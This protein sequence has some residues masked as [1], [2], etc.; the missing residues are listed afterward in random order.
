MTH[1]INDETLATLFRDARSYHKWRDK[2]VS[3][4]LLMALY[5]LLRWG[6]TAYNASPAHILFLTSK[7]AKEKLK[8]SLNP[9]NV[10]QCATAPAVAVL[11]YDL[12]FPDTLP[13]LTPAMPGLKDRMTDPAAIEKLAV[14][15]ATLQE[16][17]F[18]LA[19]RAVGL[20]CCPLSAFDA[21]AVTRD[22]FAGT[23]VKA[24]LLCTL[25]YGDPAGLK[26][27]APRLSFDEACKIL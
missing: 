9:V 11:G 3:P 26:P 1:A 5:D 24:N 19:A 6:P 15:S 27:R 25:G 14:L 20:D 21:A 2:P 16:G 22:F 8:P 10:D 12:G 4:A 17:Y 18:V 23:K 13:K 7:E